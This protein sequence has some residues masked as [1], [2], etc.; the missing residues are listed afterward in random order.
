MYFRMLQ[1]HIRHT[2]ICKLPFTTLFYTLNS[3]TIKI[4]FTDHN[5]MLYEVKVCLHL[6]FSPIYNNPYR[7][8]H[9]RL[10]YV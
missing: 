8:L 1:M 3:E 2:L 6:S 10:V 5:L 4:A 7:L 9:I